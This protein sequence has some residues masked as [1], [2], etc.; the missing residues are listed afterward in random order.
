M[1]LLFL[2]FFLIALS[3]LFSCR[4][5]KEVAI[6]FPQ[7]CAGSTL[8]YNVLNQNRTFGSPVIWDAMLKVT[9]RHGVVRYWPLTSGDINML[10]RR[11]DTN[12]DDA[13][14]Q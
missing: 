1:K 5:S 10:N 12:K 8:Q 3:S 13:K 14:A 9:D 7:D 4:A 2:A 11:A 6:E